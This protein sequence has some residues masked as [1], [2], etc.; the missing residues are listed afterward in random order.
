MGMEHVCTLGQGDA[1][2]LLEL[3]RINQDFEEC[4][5]CSAVPKM[6]FRISEAE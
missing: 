3:E 5:M 6:G 2:S 4:T 1:K